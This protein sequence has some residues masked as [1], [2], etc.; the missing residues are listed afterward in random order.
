[1]RRSRGGRTPGSRRSPVTELRGG[2]DARSARVNAAPPTQTPLPGGERRSRQGGR[3]VRHPGAACRGAERCSPSGAAC[4]GARLSADVDIA[5]RRGTAVPAGWERC[6]ASRR[7]VPRRRALFTSRGPAH[8]GTGQGSHRPG[9]VVALRRYSPAG[10]P[11]D[12]RLQAEVD[13]HVTVSA[14]TTIVRAGGIDPGST[15]PRRSPAPVVAVTC[16]R[17]TDRDVTVTDPG[18]VPFPTR[19]RRISTEKPDCHVAVSGAHGALVD[20]RPVPV[21]ARPPWRGN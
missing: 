17:W 9:R 3:G 21:R 13:R 15:L 5:P 10:R 6:S 8:P 14:S 11:A 19:F 4:A 12:F 18:G 16:K 20:D 2:L 1:M 7:C